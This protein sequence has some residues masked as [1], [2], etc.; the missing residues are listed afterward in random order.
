MGI[1][2]SSEDQT[3][4][5]NTV[6]CMFACHT[7]NWRSV[8]QPSLCSNKGW[9]SQSTFCAHQNGARTRFD[10]ARSAIVDMIERASELPP[11]SG[12]FAFSVSKFGN[13]S[14]T[15]HP[16]S[17]DYDS[18]IAAVTAMEPDIE[19]A[20]TNVRRAMTEIARTIPAS[21][22]GSS[23]ELAMN[24]LFVVTDGLENN[25]YEVCNG[26]P[27]RFN[28]SWI[29]DPDL[30]NATP[31]YWSGNQ[32]RQVFDDA[33]CEPLKRQNVRISTLQLEYVGADHRMRTDLLPHIRS[34]MESCAS[35][36]SMVYL[37][38]S[39]TEVERAIEEMFL[40]VEEMA[41]L[42]E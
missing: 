18:L 39:A 31:G 41:R 6:G 34:R 25:V 7:T 20:G 23:A 42:V 1:G 28:G 4:M 10:V 29:R 38:N 26:N 2:A 12:S 30:V 21:G 33:G 11:T 8:E 32:R 14:T 40:H 16:L 17:T 35:Q 37:A 19:G 5:R 24:H 27:C 36:S 9:W 13:Y 22:D 15:I 3:I